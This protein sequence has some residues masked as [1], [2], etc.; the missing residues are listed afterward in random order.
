MTS[1]RYNGNDE[2]GM[3]KTA[4]NGVECN[5]ADNTNK[6]AAP[7]TAATTTTNDMSTKADEDGMN[8]GNSK[9]STQTGAQKK[10]L[11]RER[12][13][14]TIKGWFP[15]GSERL[16][17]ENDVKYLTN[18]G[19]AVM[20]NEIYARH[21]MIFKPGMLKDHFEKQ[22]WYHPSSTNVQS[23]LTSVERANLNYLESYKEQQPAAQLA[24]NY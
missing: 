22:T 13:L 8:T 24:M 2:N 4:K 11:Y 16:L 5:T 17:K 20:K 14:A 7:G 23:R 3:K 9:N 10:T 15:Q 1:C 19:M 21:G 12:H 6:N 18:W